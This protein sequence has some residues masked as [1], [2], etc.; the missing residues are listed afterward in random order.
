VA[1]VLLPF[2]AVAVLWPKLPER[3]PIHWNWHGQV[4]GWSSRGFGALFLPVLNL[5]CYLLATY[6]PV[7]DP[8]MRRA[9][10]MTPGNRLALEVVRLT[11]V[12][13]VT[14]TFVVQMLSTFQPRLDGGVL[15]TNGLL[16]FFLVM[17]NYFGN[18]KPNRF[19]GIRTPWTLKS[20]ETWR[21]THRQGGRIM[22]YGSLAMLCA[23]FF[24]QNITPLVIGGVLALAAWSV[25]YS[26]RYSRR[27]TLE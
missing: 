25:F 1:L 18:L 4:D 8:R 14:F 7:L 19:V 11:L 22:V 5:A 27:L 9:A 2:A 10:E 23:Q 3:I 15:L 13:F 20:D 12:A 21:A 16:L 17:G 26:W 6:L 24:V